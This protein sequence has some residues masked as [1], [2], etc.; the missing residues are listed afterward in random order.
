VSGDAWGRSPSLERVAR[1]L[2]QRITARESCGTG[3]ELAEYM[4]L[5][6]LQGAI[7]DDLDALEAAREAAKG[8]KPLLDSADALSAS[9]AGY[10]AER[11]TSLHRLL[12]ALGVGGE[13]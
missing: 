11:D 2:D 10:P 12:R 8:F 3:R 4:K 6:E 9:F 1:L 13:R 7:V 5:G